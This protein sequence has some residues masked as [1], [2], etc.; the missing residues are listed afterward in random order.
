LYLLLNRPEIILLS[1]LGVTVWYPAVGLAFALMVA[2]SPN[3]FVVLTIGGTAAGVFLYHQPLFSWVTFVDTL[4]GTLIYGIA[5]HLLRRRLK[6]DTALGDRRDVLAYVLVSQS[7]AIFAT[8]IGVGCLWAD[9]TI[10]S[11]QLWGSAVGWYFGD[12]IG[13]LS[14]A[15]FLLIH[16]MPW[17]GKQIGPSSAQSD[18]QRSTAARKYDGTSSL[19]A[20]EFAFQGAMIGLALWFVFGVSASKEAFF[21][22]FLPIVW[23]AMRQGIRGAATGLFVLNFGLIL[24]LRFAQVSPEAVTR[25][26]LVMLVLSATGL[27]LGAVVSERN[28]FAKELK[29]R[30]DFF[31]SLIESSPFGIAVLDNKGNVQLTNHAFSSLF[32]YDPAEIVS[33]NLDRLIVPEGLKGSSGEPKLHISSGKVVQSALRRV[34]KDGQTV[35]VEVHSIPLYHNGEIDGSYIIFKDISELLK[36]SA[37]N[38]AHANALADWVGDLQKRTLQLSL[39][40]EMSELLQCVKSSEESHVI[41]GQFARKLFAEIPAGAI[42]ILETSGN[43]LE[44]IASW[45]CES[46]AAG[47]FRPDDCWAWRR[48]QP[49]WSE[50]H[51]TDLAC[52]HVDQSIAFNQLCIPMLAEDKAIGVIYLRFN[53]DSTIGRLET[54]HESREGYKRLA[55]VAA[56][57]IA[58]SLTNLKLRETLREQS[59]RDALTGLYNRRFMA[60]S[61][62]REL[63]R[64]K[65]K[66]RSMSIVFLD[67]DHFKHFND[68]FGHDAGDHILQ[69]IAELIRGH[70]RADDLICRYGGEEFAIILPETSKKDAARRAD[71][72]RLAAQRHEITYRGAL[73][74][75]V[76]LSMG[77][78]TL[79]EDAVDSQ[80]LLACA[81]RCLYASKENGRN[82]LT[83][84][85]TEKPLLQ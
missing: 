55:V 83:I 8:L 49:H 60:E 56:N 6:I 21:L 54:E 58:L 2:I 22:L 34:R 73:L 46:A 78:A 27:A 85:K 37:A 64:A 66:G 48:G 38:Q 82:R 36:A 14:V 45:G 41:A 13:L 70:F 15:P 3:Y 9:R 72:L 43:F 67:I 29:E 39:L 1:R 32:L 4:V 71:T 81:D 62:E 31:N 42:F 40:N 23:I 57:Q 11:N 52:T 80:E 28:R 76:T 50:Y 19:K 26:S 25:L 18:P 12:S 44:P 51:R 63:R 59:I 79:P 17:V 5:A 69:S 84:A 7:A 33:R 24:G 10:A 77:V 16:V 35:D 61:L 65:R 74:P 75:S 47:R 68:S 53:P 20:L 30:A